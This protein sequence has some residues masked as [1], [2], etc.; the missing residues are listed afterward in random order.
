MGSIVCTHMHKSTSQYKEDPMGFMTINKE[1]VAKTGGGGSY[2]TTSGLYDV[3]I[4]A[5]TLD[6]NEHGARNIGAYITLDGENYQMLYGALPLDLFDGS[7]E[8]KSNINTLMRLATIAGVVD[9]I[10]DPIEAT[11]PIGKDGADKDTMILDDFTDLQCKLWVKAE[12][13]KGK[14]NGVIY[15]NRIIKD[16]FT[17]DGASADEI[18]NETEAGVKM[19]KREK[20][21]TEVSYK[22]TDEVE[23][24]K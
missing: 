12:Y 3:T 14:K 16:A 1:T 23:V 20:Y 11:L 7:Q 19:S 8:I 18:T 10:S 15:E 22:D 5:L 9:D 4:G 24:A 17:T 2:I 13:S 6:I 21:F